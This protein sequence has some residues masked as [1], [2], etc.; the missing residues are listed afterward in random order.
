M[1]PFELDLVQKVNIQLV[2][3]FNVENISV[4]L[5]HF[6]MHALAK[7]LSCS[8]G[9]LTLSKFESSKRSHKGQHRTRPRF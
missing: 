6:M 3:Y 7:E 5:Q 1:L 8:Q 9:K 2:Q 4:K